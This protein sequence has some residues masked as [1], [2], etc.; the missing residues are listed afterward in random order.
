MLSGRE[1]LLLEALKQTGSV[2]DAAYYLSTH[3]N[4][5][6]RDE[7]MTPQIAYQ[8]LHRLRGRYTEARSF[9]NTILAYRKSN[10]VLRKVL[11]TPDAV[12]KTEKEDEKEEE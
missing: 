5:D 3:P 1:R 4:P 8:M 7:K 12:V 9:I 2:K 10:A 11:T 6:V